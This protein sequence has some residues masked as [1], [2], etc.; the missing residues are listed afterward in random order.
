[1]QPPSVSAASGFRASLT[2]SRDGVLAF[3]PSAA[4][5]DAARWA[6]PVRRAPANTPALVTGFIEHG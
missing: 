3:G 6:S 2:F 4:W 1:M 5:L